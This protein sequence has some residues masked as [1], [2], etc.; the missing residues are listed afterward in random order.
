[1]GYSDFNKKV[2]LNESKVIDKLKSILPKYFNKPVTFVKKYSSKVDKSIANKISYKKIINQIKESNIIDNKHIDKINKSIYNFGNEISKFRNKKTTS[3]KTIRK[4]SENICNKYFSSFIGNNKLLLNNILIIIF[5]III[6][7]MFVQPVAF[8][9]RIIS[10]LFSSISVLCIFGIFFRVNNIRA[11]EVIG[12]TSLIS[13]IINNIKILFNKDTLDDEKVLRYLVTILCGIVVF[14][15]SIL[16]LGNF[17][18][19]VGFIVSITFFLLTN[20]DYLID[21]FD[22]LYMDIK[23]SFRTTKQNLTKKEEKQSDSTS[24]DDDIIII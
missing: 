7:L 22:S 12:K 15:L 18:A 14:I 5:S 6:I 1:M 16:V 3:I 2:I 9:V 19:S 24:G 17:I 23:Q 10:F 11:S 13:M 20:I 21:L 4:Y 8:V